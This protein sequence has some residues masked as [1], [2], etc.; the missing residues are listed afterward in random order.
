MMMFAALLILPQVVLRAVDSPISQRTENGS[1]SDV[2]AKIDRMLDGQLPVGFYIYLYSWKQFKNPAEHDLDDA[3]AEVSRRGFN[4][5]YVGGVTGDTAL[6][7]KLLESCVRY[8]IG[9]VPQLEFA[10]MQPQSDIPALVSNAVPFIRKYSAHP[11]V[12]AFSVP[13]E[14]FHRGFDAETDEVL[15]RHLE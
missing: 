11:A 14:P 13:E 15:R 9:V 5:L 4:Y 1:I 3:L 2:R 10:Y 12:L 7:Q 6:W 8:H